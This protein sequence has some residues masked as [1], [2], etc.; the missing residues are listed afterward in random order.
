MARDGEHE[1][2]EDLEEWLDRVAD[3]VE[4]RRLQKMQALEKPEGSAKGISYLT[5]RNVY[6]LR[7]NLITMETEQQARGGQEDQD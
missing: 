2:E 6:I 4:E 5:T 1:P 3:E 7:K